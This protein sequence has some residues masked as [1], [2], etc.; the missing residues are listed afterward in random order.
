MEK[1]RSLYNQI[2]QLV[3]KIFHVAFLRCAS[4]FNLS[5]SL[6]LSI[7]RFRISQRWACLQ[8]S[9]E[10][11]RN[12]QGRENLKNE[13]NVPDE[14][15]L[16][17]PWSYDNITVFRSLLNSHRNTYKH[18]RW[19]IVYSI[20]EI[21]I[22]LRIDITN[23]NRQQRA[24]KSK[25]RVLSLFFISLLFPPHSEEERWFSVLQR[26][27]SLMLT[28]YAL[29][30]AFSV[31]M[32]AIERNKRL[33]KP[34]RENSEDRKKHRDRKRSSMRSVRRARNTQPRTRFSVFYLVHFCRFHS[35]RELWESPRLVCWGMRAG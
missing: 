1:M 28:D 33:I 21:R 8:H 19:H 14:Y 11:T 15:I 34:I 18:S 23:L 32:M 22:I 31:I 13:K 6:F 30:N 16:C 20:A 17:N 5:L 4:L 12:E 27:V 7:T 9:E 35:R 3:V 26:K 25:Q 29:I 24:H 2:G 10:E